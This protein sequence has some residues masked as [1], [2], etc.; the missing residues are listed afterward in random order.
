MS[1]NKSKGMILSK[2]QVNLELFSMLI[3]L[4]LPLVLYFSRNRGFSVAWVITN[5][6]C[7]ASSFSLDIFLSMFDSGKLDVARGTEKTK[8]KQKKQ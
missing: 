6:P 8:L 4:F 2:T 5:R 3:T 7:M 1:R